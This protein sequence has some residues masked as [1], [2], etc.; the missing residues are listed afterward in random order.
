[1]AADIIPLHPVHPAPGLSGNAL[2]LLRELLEG[3]RRLLAGGD[4]L[5]IDLTALPLTP[6]DLDWL[7]AR[8]GEGEVTITLRAGGES[9]LDET[10]CR[11]VWWITHR[12]EQGVVTAQFLEVAQVPELARADLQDVKNGQDYLEQL[13]SDS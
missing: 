11:G 9:T 4:P 1:M 3:V 12:N 10:A 2:P 5:A 8:L 6:A 13:L 7:R